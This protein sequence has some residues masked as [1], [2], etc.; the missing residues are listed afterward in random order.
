MQNNYAGPTPTTES[1]VRNILQG[2][3]GLLELEPDQHHFALSRDTLESWQHR[4]VSAL[5][6]LDVE[7]QGSPALGI[8]WGLIFAAVV[9]GMVAGLWL[10]YRC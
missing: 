8:V 1:E 10:I 6:L 7:P 3:S 9:W 4:L 5:L 2:V